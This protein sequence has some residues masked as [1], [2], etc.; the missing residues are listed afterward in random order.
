MAPMRLGEKVLRLEVES[1]LTYVGEVCKRHVKRVM[2]WLTILRRFDGADFRLRKII[3]GCW[4][5]G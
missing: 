4:C 5:C 3:F 1:N 2:G